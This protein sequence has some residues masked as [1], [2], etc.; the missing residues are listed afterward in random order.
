MTYVTVQ[1]PARNVLLFIGRTAVTA[2]VQT[3]RYQRKGWLLS[4][5][6]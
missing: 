1:E 3:E 2:F 4:R 6:F 5:I